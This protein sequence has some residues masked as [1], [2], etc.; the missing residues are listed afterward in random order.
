[1]QLSQWGTYSRT[2]VFAGIDLTGCI[3]KGL[4]LAKLLCNSVSGAFDGPRL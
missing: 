3:A 2:K 1:M 4:G